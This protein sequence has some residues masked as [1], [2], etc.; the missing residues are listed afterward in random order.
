GS[1]AADAGLKDGDI[2][3]KLD[4][5]AVDDVTQLRSTVAGKQPGDEVTL[6]IW[7]DGKAQSVAVTLGEAPDQS[8]PMQ[9]QPGERLELG[10]QLENLS[11][12]LQR[13][14]RLQGSRGVVITGVAPGSPA[15]AAGLRE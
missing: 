15:A 11:P 4:G 5:A 12:Q 2:I 7:R 9:Q 3:T 1:A 14:Y 13:Q 10:L 8:M 6:E